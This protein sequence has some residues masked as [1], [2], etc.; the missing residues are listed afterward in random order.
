MYIDSDF[1]PANYAQTDYFDLSFGS[2]I[3]VGPPVAF[4]NLQYFIFVGSPGIK[5]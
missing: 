1:L 2:I 5:F 4:A 3:I